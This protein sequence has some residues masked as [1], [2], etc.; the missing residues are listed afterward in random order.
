[1]KIAILALALVSSTAFAQ[2]KPT[3]QPIT[4]PDAP[5]DWYPHPPVILPV[6]MPKPAAFTVKAPTVVQVTMPKPPEPIVKVAS[7]K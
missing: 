7:L 2:W 3:V 1:M 4:L 5:Y 6:E